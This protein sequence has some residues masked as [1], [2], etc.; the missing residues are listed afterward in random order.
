MLVDFNHKR[1]AGTMRAVWMTC[2]FVFAGCALACGLPTPNTS[3]EKAKPE[4]KVFSRE[5]FRRLVL[6]KTESEVIAA[7]GRP[8]STHELGQAGRSFWIYHNLTR[9]PVSGNVDVSTHVTFQ[10]GRV[11]VVSY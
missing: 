10:D 9:D 4:K 6:G 8:E 2:V 11:E 7:V 5:E 1:G 3:G